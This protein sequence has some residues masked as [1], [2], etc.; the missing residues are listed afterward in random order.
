MDLDHSALDGNRGGTWSTGDGKSDYR[1]PDSNSIR[2]QPA[3][4]NC[5]FLKGAWPKAGLS[6]NHLRHL[7]DYFEDPWFAPKQK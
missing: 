4:E 7:A 5:E 3:R 6:G 2:R 1:A